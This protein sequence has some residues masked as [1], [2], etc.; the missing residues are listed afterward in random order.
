MAAIRATLEE[1]VA[2]AVPEGEMT[3]T[4][5]LLGQGIG[6][7]SIETVQLVLGLEAAL[8]VFIEDD[9]ML[10][11]NFRTVGSLLDLIERLQT[12]HDG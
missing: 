2:V 3:E 9:D 10:P 6:I 1:R 11:E 5:G 12:R 7:D 4:T 8:G